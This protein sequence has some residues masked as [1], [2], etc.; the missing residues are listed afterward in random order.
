MLRAAATKK[1]S[2][3]FSSATPV[4]Y[5]HLMARQLGTDGVVF[6]CLTAN[7]EIDLPVMQKLMKASQGLSVTFHRAFDVCRDP[8][9]ALEQI[10]ELG[11]NRILT[12][13]QQATCLL[14]TSSC[15]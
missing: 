5:T 6:G 11:C 1:I 13:G 4:S 2:R 14:Y 10:I 12:S 15:V 7:G 8:E 9:K 3:D